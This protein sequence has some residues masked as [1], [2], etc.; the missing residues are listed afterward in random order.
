M[1]KF[2]S[3]AL[4]L[5]VL[6]TTLTVAA[7]APESKNDR[8]M[9][10][11][12][13]EYCPETGKIVA[14]MTAEVANTSK[15][16]LEQLKFQLWANAYRADAKYKPVS[17]TFESSAYYNGASYGEMK[18]TGVSGAQSF[19]VCGEDENILSLALASPLEPGERASVQIC[20][21]VQLAEINHRL[22]I[23]ANTV[24][25]GNFYPVL[26]HLASDGFHEYVY[27]SSGDPFVSEIADYDVTLT[28]PEKYVVASG[29]AAEELADA[30]ADDG[31]RAYHV[32][33]EGVRD[34][35]FVLGESM[36][37]ITAEVQGIEIAYYYY[38][39][40]APEETLAHAAESLAFF[41]ESFGGYAYPRYTVVE[42]DF[43]YGGME[44]PALCM[45]SSGLHESERPAVVVHET[46]HQWW[47]AMVGSNQFESAW[48]DEGLAEYSSAL[49]FEKHPDYG[50][51]YHDFIEASERSYRA[52]FSVRSQVAG[53]VN[54]SMNRPLT[55]YS[56][57]YEY[58]N[59]AYDKGVILFD[60][61][62]ETIGERKLLRALKRYA[63]EY[64]GKIALPS[65]LA[66]CFAG[67]GV[68]LAG[69]FESFTEGKAV[70]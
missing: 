53:E 28:V 56:G 21:E 35:A 1:Q 23:T 54:T 70:I 45:I 36:E 8:G 9:Y 5:F 34:V 24:N 47:Y 20:F 52:F 4:A 39:D 11:I 30:N 69:L 51:S 66:G 16:A 40:T 22:G 10:A 44:Y 60:R 59:I 15:V 14:E 65:Q 19:E 61:V 55:S 38:G 29:Y 50:I 41:S 13:M 64:S 2:I 68:N 33:A 26:C 31:K 57:D 17:E 12:N 58:R 3:C 63:S 43:V 42:T 7:C 32:S 37:C 46:A 27:S 49:Y 62:R 67:A 25:L 48:Q 6:S 18:I